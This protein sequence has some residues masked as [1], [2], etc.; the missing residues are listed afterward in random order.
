MKKKYKITLLIIFI[1]IMIIIPIVDKNT[2]HHIVL[3]QTLVNI[4][5]VTGLN[6]ITG[7]TGQMNM[8]T[9]GIMALGAYTTALTTTRF[10]FPIVLGFCLAVAVGCLIGLCLGYPSLRLKGVFLSLTTIGFSEITRLVL[11]NAVEVTG[12]TMGVQNIPPI[13]LFGI[14]LDTSFKVYYLYLVFAI[15]VS[16]FAYRLIHSKW[17]RVFKAIRDNVEAVEASGIDIARMKILAFTLATILGCFGGAMYAHMMGYINP[18]TF[19]QDLS[20]NYLAMMMLGGIGTVGGNIIGAMVVTIVPELL[21]FMQNYYW[22]I[23]S[24]IALCFA[25][26]LPNGI[27]SLFTYEKYLGRFWMKS[28][29][30]K[31]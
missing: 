16:V 11:T 19:T 12:G 31:S 10:Q 3:C 17:G 26:F 27:V 24:A 18:T 25:I 22:I 4:V 14:K 1:A 29:E 21:R 13:V 2:Y 23:F 20:A 9:A 7:L 28:R 30:E 5:I 8:G 15:L 6:F